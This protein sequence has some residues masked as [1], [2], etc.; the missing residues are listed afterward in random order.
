MGLEEDV[1]STEYFTRYSVQ[2]YGQGRGR[3]DAGEWLMTVYSATGHRRPHALSF[4][5]FTALS[6]Q[7]ATSW[8]CDHDTEYGGVT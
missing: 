7:S 1:Q 3:H 4:S 6:P 5:R 2:A 8:H